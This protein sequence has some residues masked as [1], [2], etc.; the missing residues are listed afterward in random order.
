MALLSTTSLTKRFGGLVAV[1][2]ISID[3]EEGE[4]LGLIGPNGSGKTTIFN[5]V[6][7]I[8]PVSEGTITFGGEEI[9]DWDTHDIVNN[10]LARVSQESNPVGAMSVGANIKLFTMPNEVLAFSGGASEEEIYEIA[11]RVGIEDLLGAKPGSLSHADVRRLEIAK[12]IATEP[13]L[14][15]LDEPFAGLSQAEIREL[16]EQLRAIHAEG[17]TILIIDHNMKGLMEL[18]DRV[19]VINNGEFLAE[20]APEEIAADE[21]VKQAYL[22]GAEVAE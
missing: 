16:S 11:S 19:I 8:Y 5:C 10:G 6:M 21:R 17:I 22:A 9:T 14:L 4:I 20:G 18:V 3:V 2:G 12:A 15:L 1:D 13:D 7:G